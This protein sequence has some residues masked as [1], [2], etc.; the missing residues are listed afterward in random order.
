MT[1]DGDPYENEIAK[2]INGI[3]KNDFQPLI[4]YFNQWQ[5]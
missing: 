5:K 4:N 1:E 2:R 3:L